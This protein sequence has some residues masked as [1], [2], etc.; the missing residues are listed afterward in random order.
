MSA[1]RVAL[2]E[3]VPRAGVPEDGRVVIGQ[4]DT[5]SLDSFPFQHLER[6]GHWHFQ[7]YFLMPRF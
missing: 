1:Y 5:H 7:S 3:S 4:S 2:G 6:L